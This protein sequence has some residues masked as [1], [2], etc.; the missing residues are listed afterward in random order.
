[1]NF[2]QKINF[3]A[4]Y[5]GEREFTCVEIPWVGVKMRGVVQLNQSIAHFPFI[6]NLI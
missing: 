3:S 2:Q 4:V 6:A 5:M 1:M